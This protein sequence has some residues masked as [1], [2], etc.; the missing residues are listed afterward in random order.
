MAEWH[1]IDKIRWREGLCFT[2]TLVTVQN[3]S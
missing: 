2:P 1:V 3:D